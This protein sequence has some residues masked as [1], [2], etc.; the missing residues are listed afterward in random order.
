MKG[1]LGWQGLRA[2]EYTESGPLLVT[3]EHFENDKV[4]WHRCYHVSE[5]RFS[6]AP[7]IQLRPHDLMMMKDGAAMGKLAYVDGLPG[8]ACLNSHLLL[9]RPKSNS[10]VSRFLYYV[11][12]SAGFH[13]YMLA[14]RTGTTFF[15]IS[16][17]SIGAFPF[18]APPVAEQHVIAAFLDREIAKV[19][20]LILEQEKLIEL[21]EN[22]RRSVITCAVT[23]GMDPDA[24]RKDSGIGWIGEVPAHWDI[25]KMKWVAQMESG[26]TPDKKIPEYWNGGDI[27]WVS[28][29]DT[30]YLKEHDYISETANLITTKGIENSSAHLLPERAVV[31]SRDATIGRCAITTRPMAVSQHFIAWVCG[32]RI[33]PEFLLL[34]LR[35][36]GDELESLTTGATV[37]TIGMP[38]VRTLVTPV[39]P[40]EEQELIVDFV[41]RTRHKLDALTAEC[42]RAIELLRERRAALITAA[43]TGQIDVRGVATEGT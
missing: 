42:E 35:S 30:G 31:F 12:G 13:S 9:F 7:E 10:Y 16:Q 26:H 5:E 17:E 33:K 11:L 1:R 21:L 43:V 15:G 40:M 4:A 36:M 3:S 22:K 39:P 14:E 20:E 24:R 37:K 19:D 6:I 2:D 23:K 32:D 25:V 29:N 38:E 41:T 27:A 28:L 18:C 8:P 34:R